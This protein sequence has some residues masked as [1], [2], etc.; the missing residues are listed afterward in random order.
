MESI[1]SSRN[2]FSNQRDRIALSQQPITKQIITNLFSKYFHL[3]GSV[4]SL[5]C[6]LSSNKQ[7]DH[8]NRVNE[9]PSHVKIG[10]V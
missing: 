10:F 7:D 6:L 3:A 1:F 5:Y 4:L 9:F 8:Q 2:Y